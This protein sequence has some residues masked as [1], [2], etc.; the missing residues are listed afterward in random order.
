MYIHILNVYAYV[1]N[2]NPFR[3]PTGAPS[4][5]LKP[6]YT[7]PKPPLPSIEPT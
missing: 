4:A 3:V 5:I 6:A 1:N 2:N 7:V